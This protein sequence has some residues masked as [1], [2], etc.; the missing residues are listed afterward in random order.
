VAAHLEPEILIVDEVLAVGDA[1]FQ[2]KC[3]G[4]MEDVGR[5]GRT[6]LFVSHNMAAIISLCSRALLLKDGCIGYDDNAN[7]TID[8]YLSQVRAEPT[9]GANLSYRNGGR[10]NAPIRFSEI[11]FFD[12]ETMVKLTTL[13]SGQSILVRIKYR[14]IDSNVIGAKLHIGVGFLDLFN[15]RKFSVNNEAIGFSLSV[16]DAG[17]VE[18]LIP[19]FPL[20]EGRYQCYLHSKVNGRC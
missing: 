13:R 16:A 4:R 20:S 11:N 6:I 5:E 8:Y 7:E 10:R 12:A 2:K 18:L 3:L 17:V 19:R 9:N 15:Q 1:Q 14:V